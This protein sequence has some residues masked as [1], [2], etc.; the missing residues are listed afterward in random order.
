[1]PTKCSR[2]F[3]D[4]FLSVKQPVA[5]HWRDRQ[6]KWSNAPSVR[7]MKKGQSQSMG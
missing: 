4:S 2:K 3:T 6:H 7:W 5:G 1:M